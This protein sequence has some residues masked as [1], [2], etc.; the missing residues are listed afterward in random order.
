MATVEKG[1]VLLDFWAAWCGP[2]RAFAPV[3]EA[4]SERHPAVTFGK[5]DT[6][7][8]PAIAQAFDIKA[9]PTIAIMR[10]GVVLGVQAGM[11]PAAGLDQIIAKVQELDMAEV[12]R[13]I[14]ADEA[15]A[16][17]GNEPEPA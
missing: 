13:A 9:I 6:E 7:A 16:A 8:Q 15:K 1:I 11:V 3:F 5:I 10:D 2:C 12:H 14:A 17:G 4:A